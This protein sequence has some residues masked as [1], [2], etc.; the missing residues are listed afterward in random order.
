VASSVVGEFFGPRIRREL[1]LETAAERVV[2][3]LRERVMIAESERFPAGVESIW[4]SQIT[5]PTGFEGIYV[6]ALRSVG[7]PACLNSQGQ[8]GYWTGTAWRPA[9]PPLI[10]SF[11]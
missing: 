1:S 7:I 3:H 6:A 11:P 2:R 9:P 4:K 8:A 5:N 10:Q